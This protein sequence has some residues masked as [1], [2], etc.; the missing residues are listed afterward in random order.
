MSERDRRL[1]LEDML[2]CLKK[3]LRYTQGH[4]Y[5]SFV[6]DEKTTDAVIRNFEI[7]GEAA[8]RIDEDYRAQHPDVAWHRL[9]GFRNRLIHAYFGVDYEIVWDIIE[10][11]IESLVQ[12]LEELISQEISPDQ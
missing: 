9:R 8:G 6:S 1:L 3:I 4:N 2:A 12:R 10:N 7:I 5:E 11:N